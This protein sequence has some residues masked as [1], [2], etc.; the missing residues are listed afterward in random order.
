V[1]T[2]TARRC[3]GNT[4]I[5]CFNGREVRVDCAAAKL[6]CALTPGGT[7]VGACVSPAP[8][9]GGCDARETPRCDGTSI[10]YCLVGKPRS[11]LCKTSGF[12]KC[13]SSRGGPH[14]AP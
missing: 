12:G 8:S 13:E 2:G 7:P 10:R 14:C 1:C 4:S 6:E 9:A 5:A 3:E 11:Y